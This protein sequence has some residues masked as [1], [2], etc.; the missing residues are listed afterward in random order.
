[1]K[2]SMTRKEKVLKTA[3][4]MVATGGFQGAPISELAAKSKVAVGTIYHHFANKDEMVGAMYLMCKENLVGALTTALDG[5]ATT[6][7]RFEKM[8]EAFQGYSLTNGIEVSFLDQYNASPLITADQQ[9]AAEKMDQALVKFFADGIK[10]KD[11][12]K[13][14]AN[15]HLEF[16]YTN[17]FA[18]AR[19]VGKGKKKNGPKEA[20]ALRDL[21]WSALKK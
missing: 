3:L 2:K 1:M 15:T 14:E 18:A 19:K 8:W 20:E 5:K 9:K 11:F 6:S 10:S 21:T 16:F 4:Q 12:A 17:A 7:K 13:G